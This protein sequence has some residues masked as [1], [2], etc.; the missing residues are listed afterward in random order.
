MKFDNNIISV[1]EYIKFRKLAL[2]TG[3]I[4]IYQRSNRAVKH[5]MPGELSSS[6][7]VDIFR[8][9][10]VETKLSF[11]EHNRLV[12]LLNGST[13]DLL[14]QF[15]VAMVKKYQP[16]YYHFGLLIYLYDLQK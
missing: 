7:A 11:I 3:I 9:K 16:N 1:E 14:T 13:Q 6:M 5:F 15:Y 2:H 8:M 12:D 10:Y 4:P